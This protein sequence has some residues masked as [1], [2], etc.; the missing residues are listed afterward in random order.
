[1]EWK[2]FFHETPIQIR[3]NDVDGFGHVNNTVIQEYFDIGRLHYLKE[4]LG[5]DKLWK[6]GRHLVIVSNKTDFF[7]Q[8]LPD[9]QIRV[10]TRIYQLG[11][12]SLRMMQWILKSGETA[13]TATCDSVMVGV[14]SGEGMIIPD[15]WRSD[16]NQL[17]KGRLIPDTAQ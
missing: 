17:E 11:G 12:K 4:A 16:F 5:A 6:D 13:P 15:D 7:Q 3:F 9:D 2:D 10:L 14:N 8:T 1:M